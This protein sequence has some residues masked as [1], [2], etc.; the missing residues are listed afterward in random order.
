MTLVGWRRLTQLALPSCLRLTDIT[1]PGTL[2]QAFF[3]LANPTHADSIME[4]KKKKGTFL[5]RPAWD[6][7]ESNRAG[8][9]PCPELTFLPIAERVESICLQSC[10]HRAPPQPFSMTVGPAT[11]DFGGELTVFPCLPPA[12]SS[13][14]PTIPPQH[15]ARKGEKAR[16][17]ERRKQGEAQANICRMTLPSNTHHSKLEEKGEKER[18]LKCCR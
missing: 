17:R 16:E 2:L 15:K 18:P 12:Q 3:W 10:W 8:C 9:T 5:C 1:H 6:L 4:K 11:A 14:A 7:G 13:W